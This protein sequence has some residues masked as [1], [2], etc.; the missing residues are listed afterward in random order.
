MDSPEPAGERLN[1]LIV[2][3]NIISQTVLK[4]QMLK[5]GL[6][7]RVANN[8]EEA[9]AALHTNKQESLQRQGG[10][11]SFDVILMDLEMP[12]MDGL[13]AVRHI[14]EMEKTGTLPRQLVIALTGNARQG[15]IDQALEAGMDDGE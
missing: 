1:V 6:E 15:Q 11:G 2:E 8:G 7:C 14:R 13:T 9:L 12:V 10:G 3:D 5:A 4:R